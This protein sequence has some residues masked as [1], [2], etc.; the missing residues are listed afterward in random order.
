MTSEH[1]PR[2]PNPKISEPSTLPAFRARLCPSSGLE[3]FRGRTPG[4][5]HQQDYPLADSN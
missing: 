1:F 3:A 2:N 4:L 5:A